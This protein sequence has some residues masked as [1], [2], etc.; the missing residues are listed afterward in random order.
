MA[1]WRVV[2]AA[3][4]MIVGATVGTTN[5][6]PHRPSPTHI[7]AEVP[8]SRA[9]SAQPASPHG[10]VGAAL[11]QANAWIGQ[12]A[13][14]GQ[15]VLYDE[16]ERVLQPWIDAQAD[17]AVMLTWARILQHRHRFEE[18]AQAARAALDS[19][20]TAL[21]AH[22]LLARIQSVLGQRRAAQKTCAGVLPVGDVLMFSLC[23]LDAGLGGRDVAATRS[24]LAELHRRFKPQGAIDRWMRLLLS[25]AS[26]AM[27]DWAAAEAWMA[28]EQHRDSH[29][30]M[31]WADVQL[32]RGQAAQV[33]ERLAP[34]I[35]PLEQ[36]EDGLLLR[37]ALAEN[38]VHGRGEGPR[39]W[40]Q[41]A[42]QRM[43]LREQRNDAQHAAELA[44]YQ[45]ELQH[46]V[47]AAMHWALLNW[48]QAR[49][50]SDQRLLEA[51]LHAALDPAQWQ[52][53][54]EG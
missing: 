48:Q 52:V 32:Q 11:Q 38:A 46:N 22:L 29:W 42:Q 20:H 41:R 44:R 21:N 27:H 50:P 25:E 36:A 28:S 33:L 53:C 26:G 16:A 14:P 40:R 51:A 13:M 31:A 8:A 15:S 23:Q 30:L 49:E 12:A 1:G 5:A 24:R 17:A 7:V 3:V 4:L 43:D 47:T 35:E 45:L 10:D 54:H 18:A 37:L 2:R 39:I 19:P 34:L 6:E 9:F